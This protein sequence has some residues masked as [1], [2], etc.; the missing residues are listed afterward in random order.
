MIT[1]I[2]DTNVVVQSLISS[3]R[4]ASARTLDAYFDNDHRH[5]LPLKRFRKTRLSR[6]RP[7]SRLLHRV[8]VHAADVDGSLR[9]REH[10]RALA[11]HC[12][13][14]VAQNVARVAIDET[15]FRGNT[16]TG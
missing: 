10:S 14:M 1:A 5:L 16:G 12:A 13:I 6:L 7:S 8:D 3:P 4:T 11:C 9:F 15:A 2:L